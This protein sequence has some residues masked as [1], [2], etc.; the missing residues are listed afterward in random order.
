M[1]VL[2][3]VGFFPFIFSKA[4]IMSHNDFV[5]FVI[6]KNIFGSTGSINYF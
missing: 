3:K 5:V 6:E 4:N 1:I 2:K